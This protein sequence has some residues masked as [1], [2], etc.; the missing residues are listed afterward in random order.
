MKLS[1][2]LVDRGWTD[3][4]TLGLTVGLG[5]LA[6]LAVAGQARL[7]AHVVARAFLAGDGL[8]VLAPALAGFV[9]LALARAALVWGRDVAAHHLADGAKQ[10]LRARL[11][12]HLLALGPAYVH[13]E[14][15]GEIAH[16]AVDG[17]EALDDYF[18]LYLPQMALAALV[19]AAVLLLVFPLDWISGLV[20]LLTAPL[21]PLFMVLIGHAAGAATRRRWTAL[22]RLSAHFLDAL[23][24][25]PALKILGQSRARIDL[26][27]RA[28]ER[29]REL[30]ME[31]LRL[32]FL[33][34]LVL[35][36]VATLS[37]AVVAVQV[38]LRLLYGHLSFEHAF[39][40]LI[41]APEF[42][43]PLRLLGAR[44]HA[45]TAGAAA[46][47]RIF[48]V[49]D[50]R[51]EVEGTHPGGWRYMRSGEAPPLFAGITFDD[52]RYSYDGGDRPALRGVSFQVAAGETVALVGPTGAGK[53]TITYLLLRFLDPQQGAIRVDGQPLAE[54][55]PDAWRRQVAWVP[56]DPLLFYGTVA[57]NIRL[58][59]PDAGMEEVA[60]AA[61]L[62]GATSF[63]EALPEGYDT[64]VGERGARLSGG[65]IRRIALARA[66][67]E[68]APF[69]VL[70]EA[71]AHLDPETESAIQA[72]LDGLLPGRTALIV[73]HRLQ[74]VVRA[75]RILVIE[76]GQIV[77]EGTHT[78]L[79][80]LG[81]LYRRLVSAARPGGLE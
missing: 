32:A 15:V 4:F 30:T 34:A 49:L 27:A 42:Y 72:A 23:R 52:V 78:G 37:T 79:L 7:L 59:R 56:Q 60:R 73:A 53:T 13:G 63:I 41:L 3:P 64:L 55:E 8:D 68:D 25:L 61:R 10:A 66:F 24:G 33:S 57:D 50:A 45:G 18:R 9:A 43:L 28:G 14:R 77:E 29:F 1:R 12:A 69:L 22:G 26:I 16:T 19:P 44:F 48:Q 75:D 81:G 6:G 11:A 20:L 51:P 35:E 70:D 54:I 5:L 58:A 38:G 65:E 62:A 80:A 31:V 76:G 74:T 17:I 40:V 39:F 67:L 46:A 47:E 21:I 71:T 2:R 36:L